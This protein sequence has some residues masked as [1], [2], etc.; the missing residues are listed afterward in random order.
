[1]LYGLHSYAQWE[2]A[3]KEYEPIFRKSETDSGK[4]TVME[5]KNDLEPGIVPWKKGPRRM[6][7]LK[8][9]KAN[10]EVRELI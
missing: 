8:T 9:E 10:E 3:L 2:E 1:M 6:T 7:P 5:H 4:C